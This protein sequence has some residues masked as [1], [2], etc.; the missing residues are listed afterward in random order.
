M[1]APPGPAVL[2]SDAFGRVDESS[3]DAVDLVTGIVTDAR[4]RGDRFELTLC[5]EPG[6]FDLLVR[7]AAP[8][9]VGDRLVYVVDPVKMAGLDSP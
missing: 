6:D 9:A 5:T 2:R 8:A 7:D 4:F 1:S 3:P